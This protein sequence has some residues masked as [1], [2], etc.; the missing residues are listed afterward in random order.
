MP[1]HVDEPRKGLS[2]S[3]TDAF[4]SAILVP[5]FRCFFIVDVSPLS[6][7]TSSGSSLLATASQFFA[8]STR[9]Y[10]SNSH[11][12]AK[13]VTASDSFAA[14]KL[15]PKLP[16]SLLHSSLLLSPDGSTS[17]LRSTEHDSKAQT[18]KSRHRHAHS[19]T[20]SGAS[21]I[22]SESK[23]LRDRNIATA[24]SD[25]IANLVL[26]STRKR[27]APRTK[28]S[29]LQHLLAFWKVRSLSLSTK[30][31]IQNAA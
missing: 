10:S 21:A 17:T 13:A 16:D 28:S 5:R 23:R 11:L 18:G 26:G 9:S 12:S 22:P 6:T 2:V 8:P 27:K 7:D 31:P 1:R 19:S 15:R 25:S 3:E 4:V 30:L 20:V 24:M 29:S 14:L